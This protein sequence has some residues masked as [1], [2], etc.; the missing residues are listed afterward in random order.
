MHTSMGGQIHYTFQVWVD[1]VLEYV[2][3]QMFGTKLS[4]NVFADCGSLYMHVCLLLLC[5]IA[6]L[7]KPHIHQQ[8]SIF[9]HYNACKH[10]F[11]FKDFPDAP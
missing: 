3:K 6:Y 5:A 9:T 1:T 7:C 8:F 11:I 2:Q 4:T 10:N